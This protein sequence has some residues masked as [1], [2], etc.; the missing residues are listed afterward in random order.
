[1][2]HF[3]A[4]LLQ[5]LASYHSG[6]IISFPYKFLGALQALLLATSPSPITDSLNPFLPFTIQQLVLTKLISQPLG[7]CSSLY[8]EFSYLLRHLP[9]P[10][11]L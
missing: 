8:L 3:P 11:Q 9:S 5:G 2:Y 7:T 10:P 1:M 6:S 4:Q